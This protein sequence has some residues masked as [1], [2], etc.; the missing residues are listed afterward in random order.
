MATKRITLNELR[1]LVKEIINEE[2]EHER[3]SEKIDDLMTM[4]RKKKKNQDTYVDGIS[5]IRK[6]Y[7]DDF[8]QKDLKTF[9]RQLMKWMNN[10]EASPLLPRQAIEEFEYV[11]E[12]Y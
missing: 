7:G 11:T 4:L 10:D 9:R 1:N 6:K 8:W 5:A 3:L 2:K 12:N